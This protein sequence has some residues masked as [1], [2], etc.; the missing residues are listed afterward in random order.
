MY[1]LGI[2]DGHDCGAAI[3]EGKEV[4]VAVNEERFTGRK[5]EVGFPANSIKACLNF[6]GLKP[7]D[8]EEIA[9]TTTDFA[10]TLTRM[11]PKLKENYYLFRRRKIEKPR[12]VDLRRNVKYRTTE[13]K[14]KP[15][16]KALTKWYFRKNLKR[17]G[18]KNFRLHVVEHHLAH[19]AS[20]SFCSGFKKA[21]CITLDGVGDGLSSTVNI[22]KEG[23]IKRIAQSLAK[24]SLGIFFEQVTNLLGM[25]ELEDEGKVM[26]LSDYAFEVPDEENK[27]M[28]L[29]RVNGLTIKSKQTTASRYKLLKRILWNTPREQFAYMAQRVLEEKIVELFKNAIEETGLKDVCWAGGVASNIKANMRI[30]NLPELRR[31]F[32]FPHMGDGGLALGAALYV[33]H[34]LNGIKECKLEHVFLGPEYSEEEIED[35]LKKVKGIE[36]ERRDDIAEFVA[37]LIV[38]NNFV[39]WFQGRMEYGPRALGNRSILAPAYSLEIKDKLNLKIK[40]RNWFQ[41]FC[42]S[43]LKEE[44][45]KF[46]LDLKGLDKFMTMGYA[47]KP[48]VRERIKAVIS[49]DGSTRPQM[50]GDENEK[51]RRLIQEIKKQTGDGIV[52]NTSFNLH[53]YPIVCS[54]EDALKVMLETKTKY[55]ALG[56]FFI[57]LR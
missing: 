47:T 34:E 2:W 14:E 35:S 20:A 38:K 31:W 13:I 37:D 1:I 18:F 25:R 21:L 51:Y 40:K 48:E 41:P 33:N 4:K 53:G 17:L 30:K 42:P 56:N 23:K 12:L 22:F 55:M 24:D 15:F 19:A 11:F 26:A 29:F 43:L 46:F 39:L 16:C 45:K 50:L 27:L 28:N 49:L 32:V 3:V 44:V 10:K 5:L 7:S 36:Y 6:L 52:L 8:I 57:E 9:I 54:P